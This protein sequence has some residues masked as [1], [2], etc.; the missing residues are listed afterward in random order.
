MHAEWYAACASQN[1]NKF[2][3][4]EV[5]HVIRCEIRS[6]ANTFLKHSTCQPVHMASL[7]C[8][9]A[10]CPTHPTCARQKAP[11]SVQHARHFWY[12]A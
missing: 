5:E 10:C 2:Q 1:A 11:K 9:Y 4:V 12:L 6:Q 7:A 3:H 8:Y